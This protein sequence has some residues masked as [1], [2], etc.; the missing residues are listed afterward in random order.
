[1]QSKLEALLKRAENPADPETQERAW[2]EITRLLRIYVRAKITHDVRSAEESMDVV[3]SVVD[4]FMRDFR[5]RKIE[6]S[7]EEK[8]MSYLSRAV[9]FRLIDIQ[10]S[11][12]SD[13]RGGAAAHMPIGPD[14]AAGEVD[15][16]A[17]DPTASAEIRVRELEELVRRLLG[18][19]ELR[20]W[21][22][23]R[24][25]RPWDDIASELGITSDNARQRMHRLRTKLRD[26]LGRE[27]PGW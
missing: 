16:D 10:R 22:L 20:L 13:R 23:Y 7:G 5:A 18:P 3:N 17:P 11:R 21:E 4:S 26:V 19:E 6:F 9:S 1:M 15:P 27:I 12:G 25:S 24:E 8:L 14:A 2:G